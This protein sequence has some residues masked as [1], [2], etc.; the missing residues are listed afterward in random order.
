MA[1]TMRAIFMDEDRG[2]PA[3]GCAVFPTAGVR[4][5]RQ[6]FERVVW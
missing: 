4:P 3:Q 5:E 6:G 1:E 2:K